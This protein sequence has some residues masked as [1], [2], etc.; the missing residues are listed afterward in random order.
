M[1]A[2]E[3]LQ[4]VV[5]GGLAL[6]L[7]WQ[8][9]AAG[10]AALPLLLL[11]LLLGTAAFAALALLL[12][13]SLRAEAVLAVANLAWVLLAGAGLLV[14]READRG[15]RAAAGGAAVGGPRRRRACGLAR[16]AC[17]RWVRARCCWR[18]PPW[19]G[20]SW[21]A[22]SAGADPGSAG[23]PTGR[24]AH[25]TGRGPPDVQDSSSGPPTLLW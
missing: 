19:P 10:P 1:L 6:A 23:P 14:P 3:A 18:G 4:V 20:R 25:P 2:V 7:G 5:L 13:G 8:P 16:T 11:A 22:P 12:A 17:S 15:G 9:L 21:C 24:C